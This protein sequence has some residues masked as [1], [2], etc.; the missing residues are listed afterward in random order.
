M[1]KKFTLLLFLLFVSLFLGF[2]NVYAQTC[3]PPKIYNYVL[4]LCSSE[5]DIQNYLYHKCMLANGKTDEQCE[6]TEEAKVRGTSTTQSN[7]TT[8]NTVQCGVNSYPEEH[9]AKDKNGT[10]IPNGGWETHC[11]CEID[12]NSASEKREYNPKY[13]SNN[14]PAVSQQT[15]QNSCIANIEQEYQSCRNIEIKT[16]NACN[17]K[18]DANAEKMAQYYKT[19][20]NAN[21]LSTGLSIKKG[22]LQL[23]DTTAKTAAAAAYTLNQIKANCIAEKQQCVNA[24]SGLKK[25]ENANAIVDQCGSNMTAAEKEI[26]IPKAKE[27]A[28]DIHNSINNCEGME[29]SAIGKVAMG[30]A[31]GVQAYMQG[32]AAAVNCVNAIGPHVNPVTENCLINPNAAG[33]TPNCAV[34]PARS[35][36]ACKCVF[37]PNDIACGGKGGGNS[38]VSQMAGV[39]SPGYTPI[40]G[41]SAGAPSGTPS[42]GADAM[43]LDLE[44]K[45]APG[46]LKQGTGNAADPFEAAAAASAGGGGGGGGGGGDS[47]GKGKGESA[48]EEHG[49]FGGT[50]QAVKN[51]AAN[52]FGGFGS[53][54][55]KSNSNNSVNTGSPYLMKGS[56]LRGIANNNERCYVDSRSNKICM[57]LAS[58]NKSIFNLVNDVYNRKTPTFIDR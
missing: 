5:E 23:C 21:N 28:L 27:L 14:C 18:D 2:E 58:K 41:L 43:S 52:L 20:N 42:L 17:D 8:N 44:K 39:G 51:A 46:T 37:S 48:A 49:F 35:S 29:D 30:L 53:S 7:S 9:A 32:N 16:F 26:L 10:V 3:T 15:T 36:A 57:N 47:S 13:S 34:E 6:K 12:R 25:Y 40:G 24:C 45:M 54:K 19:L 11:V 50:F 31:E 22:S 4:K 55:P 1:G 38:G 33:C 56:P